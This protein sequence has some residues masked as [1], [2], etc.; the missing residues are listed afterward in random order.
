M[1]SWTSRAHLPRLQRDGPARAARSPTP[2]LRGLR[3]RF[4]NA[5]SVHS[6]RPAGQGGPRRGPDRGRRAHRRRDAPEIVFTSGGTEADNLAMRGV[7]EAL[8]AE[9]PPPS[10]RDRHRARGGPQHR[11]R[12]SRKRGWR[13]TLL[14]VATVRASW[15]RPPSASALTDDQTSLV[16][17]MLANNEIGTIQPVA[18]LA[19]ARARRTAPLCTPTPSRRPAGFPSTSRTSASICCRSRATSSAGPRASARSGCAGACRMQPGA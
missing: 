2:W 11:S 3:E 16:S 7:A 10:R 13:T 12:P 1:V 15:I 6:L 5:S 18:E 9:R 14:P 8:E 19:R 4:G 17:V